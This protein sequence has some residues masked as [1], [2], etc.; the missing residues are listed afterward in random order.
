LATSLEARRFYI[1]GFVQG[2]GYRFFARRVAGAL[3]ICGY[4]RNLFDGRVEVYAIGTQDQLRKLLHELNRGPRGA[5]VDLVHEDGADILE[6]Y[7]N[8][9]SIEHDG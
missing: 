4:V 7:A 5:T 3:G 8:D 2:V 9:F 6:N 1:S